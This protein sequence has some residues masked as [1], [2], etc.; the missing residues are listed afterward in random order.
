[1]E[2]NIK[3]ILMRRDGLSEKEAEA[4]LEEAREDFHNLLAEGKI[5]EAEE[6]CMIHFGLEP[7]YLEELI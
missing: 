2:E 6:I 7:D 4:R 3:Q 5:T 1:M